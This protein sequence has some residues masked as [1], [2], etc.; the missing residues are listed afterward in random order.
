MTFSNEIFEQETP[1]DIPV[2]VRKI[3]GPS[4]GTLQLDDPLY[5]YTGTSSRLSK[6]LK[7]L[8]L[9]D[10]VEQVAGP[11]YPSPFFA[12]TELA[13]L[14]QERQLNDVL[15][16]GGRAGQLLRKHVQRGETPMEAMQ[17]AV[18]LFS[19]RF[20]PAALDKARKAIA[21]LDLAGFLQLLTNAMAG[22]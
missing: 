4:D 8:F 5:A 11:S 7:D 15:N 13:K 1:A 18:D 14:N 10:E 12:A 19:D 20:T 17:Y 22:V 9:I 16:K 2:A 3:T 21:S 6:S